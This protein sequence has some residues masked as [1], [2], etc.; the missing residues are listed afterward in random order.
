MK[1]LFFSILLTVFF[2]NSFA[3]L[4]D[5]SPHV[6]GQL[7]VMLKKGTAIEKLLQEN[8]QLK[9]QHCVSELSGIWL[10]S[11][12]ADAMDEELF[13]GQIKRSPLVQ[14]A[15][16]NH[17]IKQRGVPDDTGFPNQYALNNTGQSGGTVDADIDA[18]EAWDISTGGL[19]AMGDT[20]VVAVIDA[21]FQLTHGDLNFWKNYDEIAGNSIDDDGNGFVDDVRGWN[22]FQHNDNIVNDQHGTHVAGIVGARGN[23]GAGVS[24]VN[25]NVKVMPV[26]G[27]TE[28][29]SEAV[30]AYTYVMNC[31][32]LYNNTNGAFG[33][34]VVATNSSFGVDM[35]QPS[36]FPIWCA[37]YDSLGAVG[38]LSATATANNNWNIDVVGDIPTACP[39]YFL[40]GVSNTDRYD[41]KAS[42]AGYGVQ[43]IDLGAPG[44]SIYSTYPTG[45]YAT[46][47]GTSM[48][49]PHVA[50][51]VALMVSA[52]CSETINDYQ[53]FPDSIALLF[54][55]IILATVDQKPGMDTL[56]ASGGRLNLF[57]ALQQLQMYAGCYTLGLNEN[58]DQ[59]EIKIF[60]NPF[61]QY[62]EINHQTNFVKFEI[63]DV[64]GRLVAKGEEGGNH[65]VD[66][67]IINLQ[68][69]ENGAY[70]IKVNDGAN[71]Y[72]RKLIK[73]D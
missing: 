60:P 14:L 1:H 47:S 67:V 18:I 25:W 23:N 68:D 61:S 28:T 26:V 39:S 33:A 48:A 11:F 15:Q 64:S 40:I 43:T 35:G 22:V 44:T 24:G 51:A 19:S 56:F 52:A 12:D 50:G 72:T 41:H 3:T 31:R 59:N 42:S 54:K 45:T 71:S 57:N 62:I 38:I 34:Y 66:N 55:D 70:F 5:E 16:F 73:I 32:R 6:K 36:N 27:A 10:L 53:L 17:Y 20:I 21:G 8:A 2:L 46:L 65:V 63:S 69:L 49:S 4:K 30:E 29:E 9:Q 7:I 58:K 13:L 37:M